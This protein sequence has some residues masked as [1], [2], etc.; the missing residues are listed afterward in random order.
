M[1]ASQQWLLKSV[2]TMQLHGYIIACDWL[3]CTVQNRSF[4]VFFHISFSLF[5]SSLFLLVS[6]F[7]M[8]YISYLY[9]YDLFLYFTIYQ[10][11]CIGSDVC[12]KSTPTICFFFSLGHRS[13]SWKCRRRALVQAH[14]P[15]VTWNNYLIN[16]REEK[17][18]SLGHYM[19]TEMTGR[20]CLYICTCTSPSLYNTACKPWF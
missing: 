10:A 3:H 15:T 6:L 2:M 14:L 19:Q 17:K 1:C 13:S 16:K 20:H 7:L 9:N 4:L 8:S 11:V 18:R 5:S 12:P